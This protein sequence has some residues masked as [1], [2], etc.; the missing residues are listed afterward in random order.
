MASAPDTIPGRRR[1]LRY[2]LIVTA[3]TA[4]ALAAPDGGPAGPGRDGS[5][6][7]WAGAAIGLVALLTLRRHPD[8][9]LAVCLAVALV[10]HLIT[11]APTG[12]ILLVLTAQ[13]IAA[14]R[15]PLRAALVL[16]AVSV[17][18]YLAVDAA[19]GGW[20]SRVLAPV[21]LMAALTGAGAVVST[22]RALLRAA[23]ERAAAAEQTK[24]DEA[25]LQVADERLRIAREL[26]DVVA[27]HVAVMGIQAGA[28]EQLLDSDRDQ[29]RAA[30]AQVRASGR[31]ALTELG[32]VVGLLRSTTADV[33][34]EEGG[35]L[36][37]VAG[38]ARLP[39]LMNTVRAAGLELTVTGKPDGLAELGLPE[40][41]NAAAYRIVQEAF[42]NA[43]KY[44][45]GTAA[46]LIDARPGAVTI[47]IT[48]P[49][50]PSDR[51]AARE[52]AGHGLV[53][54]RERAA[55]VGAE[56]SAGPDE[57]GLF[58]VQVRLP[59]HREVRS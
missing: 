49:V 24:R 33:D 6:L 37:P 42:T 41:S 55:L 3:L 58:T 19:T 23:T 21:A 15:L 48:N 59:T 32:A 51:T 20:D 9:A 26:H 7:L 4:L 31:T 38:L 22:Q 47:A 45:T 14:V 56:L 1:D 43:I 34:A 27:H 8:W 12:L 16:L 11:G 57:G 50:A 28:A 25:A 30:L 52:G 36:Q 29:V 2:G 40:M 44:G 10:A 17:A 35:E 54:M 46:L 18:A 13:F 5:L 39:E 53:G